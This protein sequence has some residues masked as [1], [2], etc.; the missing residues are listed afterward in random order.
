MRTGIVSRLVTDK[1]V[2]GGGGSAGLQLAIEAYRIG[3]RERLD[4]V[5]I[6]CHESLVPYFEW[7][8]FDVSRRFRHESFGDVAVMRMEPF[9]RSRLRKTDSPFLPILDQGTWK[10]G[11]LDDPAALEGRPGRARG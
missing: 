11:P 3:L 4:A 8:G 1:S 6:D 10:S 2:R 7:L 5:E 9:D